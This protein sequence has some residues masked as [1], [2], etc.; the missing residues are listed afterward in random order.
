VDQPR[1]ARDRL[2]TL[3]GTLVAFEGH[4]DIILKTIEGLRNGSLPDRT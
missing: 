4:R 2:E 1:G 3:W